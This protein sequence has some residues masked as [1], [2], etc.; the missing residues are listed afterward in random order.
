MEEERHLQSPLKVTL[1]AHT[2]CFMGAII[3]YQFGTFNSF[4]APFADHVLKV[5]DPDE[6]T[7]I[8]SNLNLAC[9]AGVFLNSFVGGPIIEAMGRYK[10]LLLTTAANCIALVIY[11][12]PNIYAIYAARFVLGFCGGFGFN[13]SQIIYKEILPSEM[14]KKMGNMF[15]IYHTLGIMVPYSFGSPVMAEYW[16]LIFVAPIFVELPKLLLYAT[17]WKFESPQWAAKSSDNPESAVLMAYSELYNYEYAQTK[18][19]ALMAAKKEQEAESVQEVTFATLLSRQYIRP[20]LVC[21]FVCISNQTCGIA[22]LVFYSRTIFEGIGFQNTTALTFFMGFM[23]FLSGIFITMF[24]SRFSKRVNLL[25][26]TTLSSLSYFIMMIGLLFKVPLLVI[27]GTYAFIF[28]FGMGLG[29]SMFPY[30]ADAVPPLGISYA[31]SFV[32]FLNCVNAKFGLTITNY[33]GIFNLFFIFM[34]LTSFS[35]M[36]LSLFSVETQNKTPKEIQQDFLKLK[37]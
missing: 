25:G 19:S 31:S 9:L 32:W 1:Y 24:S 35:A 28:F 2:I 17:S 26:G 22:Y 11:I 15:Y 12:I 13:L 14:G 33:F 8:A 34:M 36:V 23:N 37:F 30:L 21:I 3:G 10:T 16:R 6:R 4:F 27:I 7:A 18:T 5:T 20:F 29:G